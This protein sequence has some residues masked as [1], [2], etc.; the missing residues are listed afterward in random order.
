VPFSFLYL[1]K[2]LKVI[3]SMEDQ[4]TQENIVNET[5]KKFGKIDVLVNNA[6][7]G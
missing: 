4:A 7:A 1:S 5:V 6:G 3:G 2:I